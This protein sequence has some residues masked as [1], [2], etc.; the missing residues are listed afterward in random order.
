MNTHVWGNKPRAKVV[1]LPLLRAGVPGAWPPR[2][3]SPWG[4]VGAGRNTQFISGHA[5]SDTASMSQIWLGHWWKG[6]AQLQEGLSFRRGHSRDRRPSNSIRQAPVS[7]GMI[8]Q[9]GCTLTRSLQESL[10]TPSAIPPNPSLS[11]AARSLGTCALCLGTS[12]SH[13]PMSKPLGIPGNRLC[14]WE[15]LPKERWSLGRCSILLSDAFPGE[16]VL[17]FMAQN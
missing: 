15:R 1:L 14:A 10:C 4:G 13:T 9:M 3:L 8:Y 17:D 6:W 5:V 2:S 12:K 11:E 7:F 16:V